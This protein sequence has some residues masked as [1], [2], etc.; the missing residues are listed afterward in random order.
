MSRRLELEITESAKTLKALLHQQRNPKLKE[1]VHALYLLNN[2]RVTELKVLAELLGRNLI[3]FSA[4]LR[5]IGR[6]GLRMCL[7]SGR[8]VMV[9]LQALKRRLARPRVLSAMGLFSRGWRK[10]TGCSLSIRPSSKTVHYRLKA[11]LKV[12]RPNYLHREEIAGV[13]PAA[14]SHCAHPPWC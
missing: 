9:A 6:R 5:R 3:T 14:P 12:A 13:D 10:N 1:R 7:C 4:G 8:W 2:E 11:K